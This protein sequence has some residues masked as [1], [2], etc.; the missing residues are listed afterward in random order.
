MGF[1]LN[2]ISLKK[3]KQCDSDLFC[4]ILIF[5]TFLNRTFDFFAALRWRSACA[6]IAPLSL[7]FG[8]LFSLITPSWRYGFAV[9]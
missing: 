4:R 8:D 1:C 6:F 5:I 2:W 9:G 7:S 3:K